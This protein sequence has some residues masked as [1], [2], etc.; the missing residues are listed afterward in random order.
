MSSR[1]TNADPNLV[2]QVTLVVY[3]WHNVEPGT[4]SWVF[5]SVQAALAAA[6]AMK[7]AVKWAVIAGRRTQKVDVESERASGLVLAEQAG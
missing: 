5:P 2:R 7:N 1:F 6:R 3:E 4:L